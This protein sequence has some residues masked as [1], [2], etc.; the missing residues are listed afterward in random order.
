MAILDLWAF[1]RDDI[2]PDFVVLSKT[3]GAGLPLGAV[4]TTSTIAEAA[5]Q[6]GFLWLTTH[7]NDPA[8][9]AVG[10]KVCIIG[11]RLPLIWEEY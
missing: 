8:T 7:L 4:V 3:L 9:A 11:L 10:V 2:V 6:N 1:Q 5:R